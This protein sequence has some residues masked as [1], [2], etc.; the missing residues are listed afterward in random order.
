MSKVI[1]QQKSAILKKWKVKEGSSVT[2]GSVLCDCFSGTP[3]KLKSKFTGTVS[4]L[5]MKED[6]EIKEGFAAYN[7]IL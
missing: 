4:K 5:L 3:L 2:E 1:F 6:D 7:F